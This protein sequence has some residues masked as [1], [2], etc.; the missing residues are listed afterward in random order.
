MGCG[1]RVRK[2]IKKKLF[3]FIKI[4]LLT[5]L[6]IWK[7]NEKKKKKKKKAKQNSNF[8]CGFLFLYFAKRQIE[9][10]KSR[11]DFPPDDETRMR[12]QA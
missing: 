4:F 12:E 6:K 7:K 10:R 11:C 1:K 5:F 8:F 2:N 9:I 3:L